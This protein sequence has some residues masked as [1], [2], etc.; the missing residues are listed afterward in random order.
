M[1][2]F[3]ANGHV[4]AVEVDANLADAAHQHLADA[5]NVSVCYGDGSQPLD[6]RVDAVLVNC[7]IA[8][9]L[10][11]WLDA[12]RIG[13]RIIA[14]ITAALPGSIGTDSLI[15]GRVADTDRGVDRDTTSRRTAG[16]TD[17]VSVCVGKYGQSI[18]ERSPQPATL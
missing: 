16:F 13:G 9:P 18:R 12:L 5:P 8:H 6:E 10:P 11:V 4:V 15:Q 14:P 17:L 3:V 1:A 2:R 7:G